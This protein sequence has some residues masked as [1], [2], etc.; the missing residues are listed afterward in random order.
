MCTDL[1]IALAG[2]SEEAEGGR[3]AADNHDVDL[4]TP[5]IPPGTLLLLG[6]H[7]WSLLSVDLFLLFALNT[8]VF[9]N[10]LLAGFVWTVL[11]TDSML[12]HEAYLF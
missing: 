12:L 9:Y 3:P 10:L 2:V 6:S 8:M 4:Y 11:M 5:I 1:P 7:C